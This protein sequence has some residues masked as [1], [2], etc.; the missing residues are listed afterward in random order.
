MSDIPKK[1]AAAPRAYPTASLSPFVG[2]F[3]GSALLPILRLTTHIGMTTKG[4]AN[5]K[6]WGPIQYNS[7][8]TKI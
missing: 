3:V 5:R 2:S 6:I 4:S 1:R 8:N 7:N